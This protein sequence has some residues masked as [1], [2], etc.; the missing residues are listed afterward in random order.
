ML[1]VTPELELTQLHHTCM[2]CIHFIE[3]NPEF[4]GSEKL[5]ES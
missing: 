2:A 3:Q 1:V 4:C 5:Y